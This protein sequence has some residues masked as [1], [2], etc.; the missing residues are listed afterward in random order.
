MH[1]AQKIEKRCRLK[2]HFLTKISTFDQNFRFREKFH[3][4][5]KNFTFHQNFAEMLAEKISKKNSK[6]IGLKSKF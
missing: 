1:V 6:N 5:T 4:S 3:F 2:F